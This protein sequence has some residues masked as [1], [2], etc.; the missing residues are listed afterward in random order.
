M[1]PSD[2]P[3]FGPSEAA[4]RLCLRFNLPASQCQSVLDMFD[5]DERHATLWLTSTVEDIARREKFEADVL[6]QLDILTRSQQDLITRIEELEAKPG[7]ESVAA[8]ANRTNNLNERL[9]RL[10]ASAVT[11]EELDPVAPFGRCDRCGAPLGRTYRAVGRSRWCLSSCRAVPASGGAYIDMRASKPTDDQ[12][13]VVC[14]RPTSDIF[15]RY[16]TADRRPVCSRE[17]F[18]RVLAAPVGAYVV[19]PKYD[20]EPD[21]E[22]E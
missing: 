11:A 2:V 4:V 21:E 8:L 9:T 16:E 13:Y 10:E 19:A 3:T 12:P 18:D 20:A 14:G 1:K 22:P 7:N 17:C 6:K 5:G 15:D